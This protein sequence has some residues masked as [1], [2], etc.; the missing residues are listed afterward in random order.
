MSNNNLPEKLAKPAQRALA[1]AGIKTLS[2]LSKF[3][4]QEVADLHGIGK[5]ALV[6]IKEAMKKKGAAFRS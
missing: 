2:D 5:N 1:S 3:T 6:V 4:E